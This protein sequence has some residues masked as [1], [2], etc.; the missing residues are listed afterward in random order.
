MVKS[1][2]AEYGA[3]FTSNKFNICA[4]ETFDL[5]KEKSKETAERDGVHEMYIRF[6]NE[7][8]TFLTAQGKQP[9]FL[10]ILSVRTQIILAGFLRTHCA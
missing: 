3:L 9:Q 4:D 6:V 2:L 5:G 8:C 7:L 10:A 1:M